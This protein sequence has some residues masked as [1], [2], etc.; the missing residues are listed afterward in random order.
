M[1]ALVMS[2]LYASETF[3]IAEL[4]LRIQAM[5]MRCHLTM[6]HIPYTDRVTSEEMRQII[7]RHIY[8][9]EDIKKV[10]D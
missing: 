1:R 4:Q 9:H 6:L 8:Q 10:H 7:T 2:V 3:S 5:M